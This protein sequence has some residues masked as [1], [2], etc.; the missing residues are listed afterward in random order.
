[1]KEHIP[2]HFINYSRGGQRGR[3]TFDGAWLGIF[4]LPLPPTRLLVSLAGEDEFV[5][6]ITEVS[7]SH[8]YRSKRKN[9]MFPFEEANLL[10]H[11]LVL[12]QSEIGKRNN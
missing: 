3:L 8:N 7:G 10:G 4:P 5:E 9:L 12:L 6:D 2:F 1:M 11:V